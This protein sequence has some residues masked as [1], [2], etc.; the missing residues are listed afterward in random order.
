MADSDAVPATLDGAPP[1]EQQENIVD[2]TPGIKIF[3]GNLDYAVT[4]DDLRAFFVPIESDILSCQVIMRG[5]SPAGNRSAGYGFVAAATTE[6]AQKAIDALNGLELQGRKAI[7]ELAKPAAEKE[8]EKSERKAKR[9]NGRRGTKATAPAIDAEG[10]EENKPKKK[11]KKSSKKPKTEG[12]APVAEGEKKK[13]PKPKR[14]PRPRRPVGEEP[15]GEQ[16]KTTLFV[17]NLPFAL[18]DAALGAIFSDAGFK[19]N[20]ARVVR[21]RWGHPR[22]SKGYGFVDVGDEEEQKK[23]IEILQGKELEDGRQIAVKVAVNPK[24]EDES[25]A[26]KVEGEKSADLAPAPDGEPVVSAE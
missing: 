3:A 24:N 25:D 10:G 15:F 19:V 4:D 14:A 17:A 12:G 13:T 11:K 2:E 21:R 16:S 7:V 9:R 26:R 22:K 5:P 18:D 20:S 1:V 8:K 23:A 6:A